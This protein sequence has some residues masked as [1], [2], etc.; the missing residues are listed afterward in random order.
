MASVTSIKGQASGVRHYLGVLAHH[1]VYT[2]I[3]FMLVAVFLGGLFGSLYTATIGR[4]VAM[5]R[6][7]SAAA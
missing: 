1:W 6:G 3:T 2:L 4:V 7:Q 5:V